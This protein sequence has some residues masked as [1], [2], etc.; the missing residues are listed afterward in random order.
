[1]NFQL[2][3]GLT[4][5]C[6]HLKIAQLSLEDIRKKKKIIWK[7]FNNNN[8]KNHTI[9]IKQRNIVLNGLILISLL[10]Q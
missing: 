4:K 1:M 9:I 10:K 6:K 5:R 7:A 3:R 8:N 2:Q